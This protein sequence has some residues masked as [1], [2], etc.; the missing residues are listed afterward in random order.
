MNYNNILEAILAGLPGVLIAIVF[1]WIIDRRSAW[2]DA[3]YAILSDFRA[4]YETVESISRTPHT[5]NR[6]TFKFVFESEASTIKHYAKS[7]ITKRKKLLIL[8][9]MTRKIQADLI[10]NQEYEELL[11]SLGQDSSYYN[12]F[13]TEIQQR[14]YLL[15]TL[16]LNPK[17]I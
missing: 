17:F 9:E 7:F 16:L 8:A 11:L 5:F 1:P 12:E 3:R 4:L 15:N 14:I 6:Y 10:L 13:L 2:R